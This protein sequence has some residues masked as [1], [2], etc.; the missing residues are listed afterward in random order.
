MKDKVLKVISRSCFLD[1]NQFQNG[2][3][4][5]YVILDHK[6]QTR[7]R[8]IQQGPWKDKQTEKVIMCEDNQRK[9]K[10]LTGLLVSG[11]CSGRE[12]S[13]FPCLQGKAVPSLSFPVGLL[14]T[15]CCY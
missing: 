11:F 7:S 1:K 9:S 14:E 2:D 12:I 3:C 10:M 8:L 15:Y 13:F 4:G 6:L 5:L